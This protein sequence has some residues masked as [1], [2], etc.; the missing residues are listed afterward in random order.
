MG[1]SNQY[2]N[3]YICIYFGEWEV[4][5]GNLYILLYWKK[6]IHFNTIYDGIFSQIIIIGFIF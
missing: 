6:I 1:A 5:T 2:L 4:P 3:I